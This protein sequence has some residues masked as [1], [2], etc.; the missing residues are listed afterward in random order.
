MSLI[1]TVTL[2]LAIALGPM[3]GITGADDHGLEQILAETATTPA[4]HQALAK[5]YRAKAADAKAEAESHRTVANN[6]SAGA[7]VPMARQ[8][9]E[10]C[11][12]LASLADAEASEYEKLA[13]THETQAK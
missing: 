12:K 1:R 13:A 3:V 10:H 5:Y 11:G 9:S 6:Y 8:R 2:G 4:Q 7:S